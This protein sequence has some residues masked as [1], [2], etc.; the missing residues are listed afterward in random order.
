MGVSED[1]I[2]MVS[3]SPNPGTL[4]QQRRGPADA[5][6]AGTQISSRQDTGH[7]V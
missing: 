4:G 6:P 3:A 2:L 1:Y 7:E 5:S